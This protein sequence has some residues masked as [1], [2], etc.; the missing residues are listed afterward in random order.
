MGLGRLAQQRGG[1]QVS[2][3]SRLNPNSQ[4]SILNPQPS[5]L[6]LQPSSLDPRKTGGPC[7]D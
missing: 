4:P 1:L 2:Q 6:N 5:G 3:A 7:E